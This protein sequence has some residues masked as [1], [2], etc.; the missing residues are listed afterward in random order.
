MK[1]GEIVN[2]E[3]FLVGEVAGVEGDILEVF[4]Y[5]EKYND[6]FVG[7]IVLVDSSDIKLLGIV[8]KKAHSSRYGTFAPL[9]RSREELKKAYPDI[10]RYHR[11]VSSILYTSVLESETITHVRK[12]SPRLHD[13]VYSLGKETY[14][15]EFLKPSGE[16]DLKF[17]DHLVGAKLPAHLIMEI[18]GN[19]FSQVNLSRDERE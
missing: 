1:I 16:W 8:V 4:I 6:V 18:L 3:D 11:Y 13:R 5:P 14:V 10:D 17:L 9:R 19:L 7:S 15:K 2:R 12:G